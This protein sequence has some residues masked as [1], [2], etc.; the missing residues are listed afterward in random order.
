MEG[1]T[2]G[3]QLVQLVSRSYLVYILSLLLPISFWILKPLDKIPLWYLYAFQGKR[4]RAGQTLSSLAD[5]ALCLFRS[6][7]IES[8]STITYY[9]PLTLNN[10]CSL[11]PSP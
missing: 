1:E 2:K 11:S 9:H 3:I 6:S 7:H 4:L 5:K 10:G 8:I